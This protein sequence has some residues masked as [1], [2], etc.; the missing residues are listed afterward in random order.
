MCIGFGFIYAGNVLHF[1]LRREVDELRECPRVSMFYD[2]GGDNG[3]NAT[4]DAFVMAR[5]DAVHTIPQL[6][7]Y[8]LIR[9][10]MYLGSS[11]VLLHYGL[12]SAG[13]F[14]GKSLGMLTKTI[15]Y[16]KIEASKHIRMKWVFSQDLPTLCFYLSSLPPS[17]AAPK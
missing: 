1:V 14:L 12:G 17:S 8:T 9:T 2:F 11:L 7:Y 15:I 5:A 6:K 16:W 10:G 3:I 13:L 4:I